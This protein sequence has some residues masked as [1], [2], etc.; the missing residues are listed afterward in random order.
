ML[1]YVD[2][3]TLLKRVLDEHGAKQVRTRLRQLSESDLLASSSLAWIEVSR[4]MRQLAVRTGSG[5]RH[6]AIE[7][8]LS[9][10]TER[11]VDQQVVSLARRIGPD[12]LRS[13]DAIHVAT[14]VLLDADLVLTHDERM[15]EACREVGLRVEVPGAGSS[16]VG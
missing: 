9:G 10:V 13:L 1:V 14:A 11:P 5:V 3:S 12:T 7:V 15:S 2:S 16:I 8:A 4:A 6:D